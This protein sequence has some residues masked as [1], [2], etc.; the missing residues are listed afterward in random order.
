MIRLHGS[1]RM[2]S[3]IVLVVLLVTSLA[4]WASSAHAAAREKVIYDG[5]FGIDDAM[6]LIL[7]ARSPHFDLIGVTSVFGNAY[8]DDTTRNAL[9]LRD[10]LGFAAPVARGAAKPIYGEASTPPVIHGANGLGGY[11]IPPIRSH[12]DPRPAAQ[13]IVDLVRA[14]PHQVTIFATGRMTNLAI[15]L[16]EAPG[17]T[18]L[19]KRVIIMGGAFGYGYAGPRT[20]QSVWAVA[21][22]N[23]LG[24]PVSADAVINAGWPVTLIPLDVTI[25]TVMDKTYLDSLPGEDGKLIRAITRHTYVNAAGSMPV[26]DPS[27]VLYALL[28]TAYTM[29]QGAVRVGIQGLDFG[30][31]LI[32]RP[33]SFYFRPEFQGRP[34]VQ[35]AVNVDA[36][37]VL[38]LYKDTIR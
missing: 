19:V 33:N 18:K 35:V 1:D 7:V 12:V 20:E 34:V 10:Y 6:A 23:I 29:I 13:M 21:E 3:A 17:I 5:D 15:A 36:P 14:N 37:T 31:T 4:G 30:Q 16:A 11:D 27:A 2:R 24:D 26:H 8:I 22:A 38:R 32:A 28:P 25:R 9:F